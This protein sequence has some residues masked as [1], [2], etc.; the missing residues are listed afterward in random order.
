MGELMVELNDIMVYTHLEADTKTITLKHTPTGLSVS[1]I[2]NKNDNV[3]YYKAELWKKL[4]DLVEGH[5][6]SYQI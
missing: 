1:G 5:K 3:V 6:G 2:C 4:D